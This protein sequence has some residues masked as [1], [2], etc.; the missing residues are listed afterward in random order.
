MKNLL[1]CF[2]LGVTAVLSGCG[3][4]DAP[5]NTGA[6]AP[7][8]LPEDTSPEN[9]SAADKAMMESMSPGGVADPGTGG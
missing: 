1:L 2:A 5:T 8:P 7:P 4:G 9:M 6:V 3:G